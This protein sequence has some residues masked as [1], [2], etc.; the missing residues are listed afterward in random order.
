MHHIVFLVILVTYLFSS[1]DVV[2]YK[3]YQS[4]YSN[5]TLETLLQLSVV[6]LVEVLSTMINSAYFIMQKCLSCYM[7]VEINIIIVV[8]RVYLN[9]TI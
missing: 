5:I 6:N 4:T 9:I 3:I 2:Q 7:S 8:N 1:F